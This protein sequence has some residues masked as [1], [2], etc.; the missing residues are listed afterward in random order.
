MTKIVRSRVLA[1]KMY[2]L[3]KVEGLSLL[4]KVQSTDICQCVNIERPLLSIER[5]QLRFYGYVKRTSRKETTK[6]PMVAFV[7]G[8]R[9]RERPRTRW[10]DCAEDLA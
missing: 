8:K 4:D 6:Q 1:A 5:L 3:Q 2:F 9:P 7:S 10:R